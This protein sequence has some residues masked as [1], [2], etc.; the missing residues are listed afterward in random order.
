MRVVKAQLCGRRLALEQ[1]PRIQYSGHSLSTW[2]AKVASFS[3]N[4]FFVRIPLS[5]SYLQPVGPPDVSA[6]SGAR[7]N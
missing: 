6:I 3:R 1:G 4:I 5:F 7:G 2:W